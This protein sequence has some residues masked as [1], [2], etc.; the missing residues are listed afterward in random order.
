MSSRDQCL[1]ETAWLGGANGDGGRTWKGGVSTEKWKGSF[2][3][4]GNSR[5][6]FLYFHG[7]FSPQTAVNSVGVSPLASSSGDL[8]C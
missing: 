6:T 3:K 1:L 5:Q 8:V 4:G 7:R 2:L